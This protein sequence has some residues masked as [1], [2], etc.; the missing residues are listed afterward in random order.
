[1]LRQMPDR[2][3][4]HQDI[5]LDLA[6]DVATITIN[7]PTRLNALTPAALREMSAA[8]DKAIASGARALV[9]TG[10]DRAFSSGADLMGARGEVGVP[11]DLGAFVGDNF[12]PVVR[13]I[14]ALP[15]PVIS[16]VRG[17]AAGAG[18]SLALHA[19][20][21]IAGKSAYFLLAFVNIGLVPDAGA[22]WLFARAMGRA[23]ALEAALLGERLY[24]ERAQAEGLIYRAVEDGD[25][26]DEARALAR[27]LARGPTR[28]LGMIRQS[29]NSALSATL[30][31]VLEI[32]VATQRRAGFSADGKEGIAAFVEKR[33][34][35]FKGK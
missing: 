16:A 21:V 26:L 3:S 7:R 32:E 23:R 2:M 10:D 5:L 6:D 35:E 25:V 27:R 12:N 18:C 28:T 19:D 30:D 14:A 34:A 29:V 20:F 11:D 22:T 31:D 9:M 8:I 13:Q 33:R 1:M 17:L 24:A 15:I 4:A